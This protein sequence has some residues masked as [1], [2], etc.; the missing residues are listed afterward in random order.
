MYTG[1]AKLGKIARLMSSGR[2]DVSPLVT[3]VYHGWEQMEDAVNI[4]A[5]KPDNLIKPVVLFD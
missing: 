2:L 3:H 4:M 5:E 1:R